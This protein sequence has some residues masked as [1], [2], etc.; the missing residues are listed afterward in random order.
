MI[1][2]WLYSHC[3]PVNPMCSI[4]VD[5]RWFSKTLGFVDDRGLIEMEGEVD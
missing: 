5:V 1:R 3:F 2:Y 4:H